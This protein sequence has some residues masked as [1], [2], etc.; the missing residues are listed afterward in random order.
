MW[1]VL[2]PDSSS[3]C[4]PCMVDPISPVLDYF[5]FSHL[6]TQKWKRKKP[7]G[8]LYLAVEQAMWAPF[9]RLSH[10]ALLN[11]KFT[12]ERISSP[13]ENS[14]PRRRSLGE[15]FPL[16]E[17]IWTL[18]KIP[19]CY[20]LSFLAFHF[21]LRIPH[22]LTP[23]SLFSLSDSKFPQ[24][25]CIQFYC[26]ALD[27]LLCNCSRHFLWTLCFCLPNCTLSFLTIKTMP[28]LHLGIFSL[29]WLH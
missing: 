26:F 13:D 25:I 7:W 6:Q 22:W 8:P 1:S 24:Y 21:F 14:L 10:I 23:F 17:R 27:I 15:E 5:I 20:S 16:F 29:L 12:I 4:T 28:C 3:N 11:I 9:I 18:R 2:F 19:S